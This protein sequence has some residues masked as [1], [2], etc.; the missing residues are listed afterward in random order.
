L[1]VGFPESGCSRAWM[2]QSVNVPER[3]CS[4]A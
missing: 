2:F 4:T 1:G 3:E